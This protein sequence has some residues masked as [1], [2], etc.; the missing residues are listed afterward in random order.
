VVQSGLHRHENYSHRINDFLHP[1][2]LKR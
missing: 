1:D 2:G